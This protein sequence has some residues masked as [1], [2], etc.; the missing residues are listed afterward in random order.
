MIDVDDFKAINDPHGHLAG[1]RVLARLV[2]ALRESMRSSDTLRR[3]GG[4]EF[5][6]I[7]PD[8]S[9]DDAC[10]VVR[11]VLSEFSWTMPELDRVVTFSA[12]VVAHDPLGSM[13]EAIRRADAAAY[14]AKRAGKNWIVPG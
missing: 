9:I 3:F 10:Q 13:N 7:L 14:A 6:L 2:R 4:E 5:V 1:D 12:G 11:R 8:T